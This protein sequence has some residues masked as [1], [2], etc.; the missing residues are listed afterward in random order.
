LRDEAE[1][2]TEEELERR[3]K[4]VEQIFRR[5]AELREKYGPLDIPADELKQLARLEERY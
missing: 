5:R 2:I 4:L 3:R 1:S